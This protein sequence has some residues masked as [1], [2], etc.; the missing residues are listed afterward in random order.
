MEGVFSNILVKVGE[1]LLKT[2]LNII[3]LE[4]GEYR[5]YLNFISNILYQKYNFKNTIWVSERRLG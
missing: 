1:V 4:L 5:V 2:K 3:D